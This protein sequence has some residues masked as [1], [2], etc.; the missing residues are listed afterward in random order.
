[1]LR[2]PRWLFRVQDKGTTSP[3][4]RGRRSLPASL[5]GNRIPSVGDTQIVQFVSVKPVISDNL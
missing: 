1:L 5:G 4:Q 2:R 3:M